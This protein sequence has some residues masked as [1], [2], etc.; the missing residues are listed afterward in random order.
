MQSLYYGEEKQFSELLLSGNIG[1][2]IYCSKFLPDVVL[3]TS[4]PLFLLPDNVLLT[5][6]PLFF[7]SDEV[8]LTSVPLFLLSDE[9][10]LTSLPLFYIKALFS[11]VWQTY[12]DAVDRSLR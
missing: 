1:L 8:L 6:V 3:L 2:F 9:V 4:V 5:S 10:L 7:L 11:V 12:W